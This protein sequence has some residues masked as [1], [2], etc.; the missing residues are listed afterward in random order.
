MKRVTLLALSLG[1]LFSA[2]MIVPQPASSTVTICYSRYAVNSNCG[3][4]GP[5]CCKSPCIIF[6][7]VNCTITCCTG[8]CPP[9]SL[10][11]GPVGP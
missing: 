8:T 4:I 1:I 9:G 10:G 11:C 2:W 7:E 3:R 6:D 5:A